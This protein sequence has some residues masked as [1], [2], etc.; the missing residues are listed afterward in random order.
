M[1]TS[2]GSL[3]HND[4]DWPGYTGLEQLV[5]EV[6]PDGIQVK[7]ALDLGCGTGTRTRALLDLFPS[8][9][10]IIGIDKDAS[11]VEVAKGEK[12]EKRINY[13]VNSIEDLSS[14]HLA[15]ID[16]VSAVYVLHW[17]RGKD[18]LFAE[19]NNIT[20]SGAVFLIAT[21]NGLPPIYKDIDHMVRDNLQID[22]QIPFSFSIKSNG[23]IYFPSG[24]GRFLL[25]D[26]TETKVLLIMADIVYCNGMRPVL[27]GLST[28]E[29]LRIFQITFSIR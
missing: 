3:Y 7:E 2:V 16:C 6:F 14:L 5:R 18:L 27:A 20:K 24:A 12:A 4:S 1:D 22:L 28:V 15:G 10:K 13:L 26:R 9:Q 23:R 17:L 19:L 21:G 29:D 11:M 8:L 25:A